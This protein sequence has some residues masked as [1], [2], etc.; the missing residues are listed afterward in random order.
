MA[1]YI[2][3]ISI[4][5]LSY[6]LT[7]VAMQKVNAKKQNIERRLNQI[8]KNKSEINPRVI[9][10]KQDKLKKIF[11]FLN[12]KFIDSLEDELSMAGIPLRIEEY[13]SIWF[14]L[15]LGIPAFAAFFGAKFLVLLALFII[16]FSIPIVLIKMKKSKRASLFN[17]QLID[18]MAIICNCLRTGFSFQTAMESVAKE[19]ADP[20]SYEFDRM[21]RE[22]N[23]GL[24][25][26]ECMAKM[27]KRTGN[28]DLQL[29]SNAVI[30]Q[31]QVGGNL[32]EI[33]ESISDTIKERVKISDEIRV[34][35]S[36]GRVSGYIVGLLPVFIL[37]LLMVINPTY[38]EEFFVT[39]N[40]RAILLVCV[41]LESIGFL[42]VKKIV[43]VKY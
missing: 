40:G 8:A 32:A 9:V 1:I 5:M 21:L 38:V 4:S 11:S 6:V 33:L 26:E 39:S 43:S 22:R 13:L 15:C 19:M 35:T 18:A 27:I 10:G 2:L 23:L 3:V 20:I 16:G 41:V 31:K 17:K 7:I 24:S 34:L 25:L 28:K 30:I 37:I 14:L 42:F 36:T 29:I 12:F